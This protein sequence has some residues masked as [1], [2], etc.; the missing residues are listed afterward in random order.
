MKKDIS[1]FLLYAVTGV[2]VDSG[3]EKDIFGN[4]IIS[5]QRKT[6]CEY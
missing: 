2:V 4:Q 5:V 3:M 1:F 6:F